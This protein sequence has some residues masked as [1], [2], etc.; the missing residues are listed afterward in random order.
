MNKW[1][2]IEPLL[3]LLSRGKFFRKVFSIWLR[4]SVIG[5][6][7]AGLLV[8]IALWKVISDMSSGAI[9]GGI[10]FQLLWIIAVYAVVHIGWIRSV[11][12]DRLPEGKFT[13]IPI[14]SLLLR[15][16]GEMYAAFGLVISLGGCIFFWFSGNNGL[17]ALRSL[18]PL[19]GP[20]LLMALAGSSLSDGSP[21]LEGSLFLITGA[22]TSLLGLIVSYLLAE[23]IIVITEVALNTQGILKAVGGDGLQVPVSATSQPLS[24]VKTLASPDAPTNCYQCKAVI[25]IGTR[26]CES[27][28][29]AV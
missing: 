29:T 4:V 7:L 13:M 19:A 11:D 24:D 27:C 15:M 2:F 6:A 9:I 10:L 16:A 22:M 14:A 17:F 12:I 8:F 18:M 3:Q 5:F 20:S 21:L 26:F 28:G 25:S 23:S 1:L